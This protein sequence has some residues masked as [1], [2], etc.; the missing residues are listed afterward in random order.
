MGFGIFFVIGGVYET[1][2][3]NKKSCSLMGIWACFFLS[4]GFIFLSLKRVFWV[5]E[6]QCVL[7]YGYERATNCRFTQQEW[8]CSYQCWWSWKGKWHFFLLFL[9]PFFFFFN[10]YVLVVNVFKMCSLWVSLLYFGD[11]EETHL[12]ISVSEAVQIWVLNNVLDLFYSGFFFL[13]KS[14]PT[15][16]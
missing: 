1:E 2:R 7:I 14:E 8:V 16:C 3:L 5:Y 12:F 15:Q 6:C 11:F 9:P 13:Y 10:C 4:V